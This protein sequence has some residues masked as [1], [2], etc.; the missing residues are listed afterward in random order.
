MSIDV[1]RLGE[2]IFALRENIN[3]VIVNIQQS[4]HPLST[5]VKYTLIKR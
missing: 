5:D 3:K 1:D 2:V 4:S